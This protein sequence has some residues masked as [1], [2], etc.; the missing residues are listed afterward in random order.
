MV[1]AGISSATLY[2]QFRDTGKEI[3]WKDFVQR[4]LGRGMVRTKYNN[5]VKNREILFIEIHVV[6]STIIMPR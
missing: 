2:Y 5:S 1:L 4:Y 3:T 6:I